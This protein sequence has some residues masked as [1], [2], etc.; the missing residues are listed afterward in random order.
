MADLVDAQL[1]GLAQLAVGVERFLLEE[2]PHLAAAREELF[3]ARSLLLVGGED[4]PLSAGL[5]FAHELDGA[6]L[7]LGTRRGVDETLDD[8]GSVAFE[9]FDLLIAQHRGIVCPV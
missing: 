3:V 7:E 6:L 1:L 5:P 2:A 4:R 9:L 8:E